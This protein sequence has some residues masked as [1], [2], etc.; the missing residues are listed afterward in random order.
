MQDNQHRNIQYM[1]LSLTDTCNFRC[2]Y[3]MDA[4]CEPD[5]HQLSLADIELICANLSKLGITKVK[6]TGGEPL[7]RNDIAQ[8]VSFLKNK[9]N[10]Q[11]VTLTTNGALLD[12]HLAS[13]ERAGLDAITISIDS[14]DQQA[15]KT[16]TRRKLFDRVMNNIDLA[17]NSSI[18][19]IKLNVVPLTRLGDQNIID[20][21]TYAN[22][23]RIPIRFIEMMPIGLGRNY[24][25]YNHQQLTKLLTTHF[26]QSA[27]STHR[28][29]NGPASYYHF[30][31]LAIDIGIISALD[32][33]F[34]S[35]CNRIRI[36]STGHLKQ[37]LHYSKNIDL[38]DTLKQR[39]GLQMVADFIFQKPLEHAMLKNSN[40]INENENIETLTMSKIGG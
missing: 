24:P 21:C 37:C 22:E 32:N 35:S 15:F 26:G 38:I 27:P 31:Q 30:Q 6:L 17:V 13:L 28:H 23:R 34:C 7:V 4:D 1:R 39:D 9:C 10:I 5:H 16:V 3:C 33:K 14:I 8:I 40:K 36:T 29:G 19:N 11:E 2:Q 20:L 25:G 12:K 18:S